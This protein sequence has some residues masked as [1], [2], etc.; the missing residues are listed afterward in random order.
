M[1][2]F[3]TGF[4]V[5]SILLGW[6]VQAEG[7]LVSLSAQD[8]PLGNVL[9]RI[10]NASGVDVVLA[11]KKWAKTPVSFSVKSSELGAAL[12]SVLKSY[13][14]ALEW[15]AE[16]DGFSK[17]VVKIHERKDCG[18]S[19]SESELSGAD[20]RSVS[21]VSDI[22]LTGQELTNFIAQE[23]EWRRKTGYRDP[24]ATLEQLVGA[25]T[26]KDMVDR[27]GKTKNNKE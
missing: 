12:N 26:M 1:N 16:D 15:Y 10:A 19:E 11:D 14:Y 20:G 17:V 23:I 7:A 18:E 2:F 24:G 9:E 4:F 8:E 5:C 21:N 6:F 27:I 13:D 3:R 22:P 25:A